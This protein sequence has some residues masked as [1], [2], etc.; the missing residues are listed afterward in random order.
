[1]SCFSSSRSAGWNLENAGCG[2]GLV[3]GGSS[4]GFSLVGVWVGFVGLSMGKG[5]GGQPSPPSM[6][7]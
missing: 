3:W 7:S 5:G 1:M 6:L 4:V 2:V